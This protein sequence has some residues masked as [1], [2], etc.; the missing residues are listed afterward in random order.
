MKTNLHLSKIASLLLISL[1][2]LSAREFHVAITGHDAADGSSARPLRT[3]QAAA[4]QAKPGDSITVHEGIY[5]ERVSPPRGGESDTKRIVYQAAP[6]EK[7]VITGSEPLTD[8]RKVEG[9][10]WRAVIRNAFFG[11]FNPY[12][13]KVYGDWFASRDRLYHRGSVYL[14]HHW[15]EEAATLQDVLATGRKETSIRP[16]EGKS[17]P[18]K[19][20]TERSRPLWY[21]T[22]EGTNTTIWAQFP[23]VNPNRANVEINVRPTVFTPQKPNVDYLTVSG[24]DLRN[25]GPNWAAPTTGQQG[26][27]TAYWCKGWIIED[28]EISYS[29]CSGI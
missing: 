29:I 4:N 7:V 14:D 12:A 13:E 15:L 10:I 5:R 28:N 16:P 11:D 21:A 6:G 8:W 27:L 24:F 17:R 3:I 23:G 2:S 22:V 9:D 18:A 1:A 25:A 20:P 19:V 26:L